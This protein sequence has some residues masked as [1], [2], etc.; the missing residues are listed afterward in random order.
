MIFLYH[1]LNFENNVLT[2]EIQ[3]ICPKSNILQYWIYS[4]IHRPEIIW[5]GSSKI[6]RQELNMNCLE[7]SY[8]CSIVN[9]TIRNFFK[10]GVSF[11]NWSRQK[12]KKI[13]K[14]WLLPNSFLTETKIKI[15]EYYLPPPSECGKRILFYYPLIFITQSSFIQ[16]QVFFVGPQL[17]IFLIS[18]F[19][20]CHISCFNL[21]HFKQWY[22]WWH[23]P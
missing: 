5:S 15:N 16:T 13:R 18:C 7:I 9:H 1:Y 12:S 3:F 22:Q 4:L 14:P 17:S 6:V 10:N 11:R 2:Y 20:I 8:S 21:N 19:E 23:Y